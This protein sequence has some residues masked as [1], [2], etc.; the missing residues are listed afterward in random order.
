[1]LLPQPGPGSSSEFGECHTIESQSVSTIATAPLV[2]YTVNLGPRRVN[3]GQIKT[4]VQMTA[5]KSR[6]NGS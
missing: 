5:S 1:M 2:G 6:L 3:Q 4:W